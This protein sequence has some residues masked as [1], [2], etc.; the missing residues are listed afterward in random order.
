MYH[1]RSKYTRIFSTNNEQLANLNEILEEKILF[2]SLESHPI[3][4]L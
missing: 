2:F 3:I 4:L 1:N